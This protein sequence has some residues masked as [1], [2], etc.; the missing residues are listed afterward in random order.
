MTGASSRAMIKID[1]LKRMDT[2]EAENGA[3]CVYCGS[4][5]GTSQAYVTLAE[6]VGELLGKSNIRLVY[7]GGNVGLMGA[8]AR[9]CLN[10]GGKVTGVIPDFLQARE[11][12]LKEADEMIV[13]GSMHERKQIMFDRADAFVVLPGGIGT[14]DET[15]EM[16]T[17]RQLSR[18][19]KPIYLMD[20]DGFWAPLVQLFDHMIKAGFLGDNVAEYYQVVTSL[21]I[22]KARL[23]NLHNSDTF[24]S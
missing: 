5:P 4:R 15:I 9:A 18:H 21:D 2:S 16:M 23:K 19:T 3:V 6:N 24:G 12:A 11:L 13:T 14:L 22:L 17:W 20:H 8:T 7:G 1:E 10:A